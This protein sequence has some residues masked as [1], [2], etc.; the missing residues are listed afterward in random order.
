MPKVRILIA[1]LAMVMLLLLPAVAMAQP[2]V[3][4]FYGSV[5]LDGQ[6]VGDGTT[7][8]AMID[9]EDVATTTTDGSD[10]SIKV[11]GDYA[12]KTVSFVVGDEMS[13][14]TQAAWEAGKNTRLD[15]SAVSEAGPVGLELMP[16]EGVATNVY[17]SGFTPYQQVTVTFDG[18]DVAVVTAGADGKFH[19]A[20]IPTTTEAGDYTVAASDSYERSAEASF[21]L[22]AAQ[23]PEGP[24]GPQ[25]PAGEEGPQGPPGAA[26]EDGDDASSVLGIVA[27]ILAVIAV[28][29][30]IVFGMRSKQPAASQ[31]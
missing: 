13:P 17:G 24:E 22:T 25:G 18:N 16:A 7:V 12:G 30:A 19:A 14:A 5:M 6:S 29:L 15:L 11:A 1:A 21:T 26:G 2:N 27:I 8:T 9:G 20:V 31:P 10:Y 28:I 4:G 3:H 23:G